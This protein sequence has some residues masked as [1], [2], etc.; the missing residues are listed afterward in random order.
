LEGGS[1]AA[2]VGA[3]LVV[4]GLIDPEDAAV[5]ADQE[6]GGHRERL[7][8][9]RNAGVEAVVSEAEAIRH[10]EVTIGEHRGG[11]AVLLAAGADRFRRVGADGDDP[12]AAGIQLVPELFPSP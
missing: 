1:D 8:A 6:R 3:A 10:R 11:E 9:A 12:D 2:G 7:G 4:L 5:G